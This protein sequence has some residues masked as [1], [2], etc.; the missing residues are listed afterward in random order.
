MADTD[1]YIAICM[2]N[3]LAKV[4]KDKEYYLK[5]GYGQSPMSVEGIVGNVL[6]HLAKKGNKVA[7]TGVP[8]G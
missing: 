6:K 1:D 2:F 4:D 7:I 5:L 8:N 3:V